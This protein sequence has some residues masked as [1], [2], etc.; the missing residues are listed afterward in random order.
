MEQELTRVLSVIHEEGRVKFECNLCG[1]IHTMWGLTVRHFIEAH[2]IDYSRE[3]SQ[4]PLLPYYYNS[5]IDKHEK[6]VFVC[7]YCKRIFRPNK[8]SFCKHIS[9]K[10]KVTMKMLEKEI[11]ENVSYTCR[12]KPKS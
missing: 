3:L 1:K 11:R 12:S 8:L 6:L 9:L 10:H 2:G 5:F 4:T 7:P